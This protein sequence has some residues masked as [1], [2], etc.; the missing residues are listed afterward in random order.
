MDSE[1]QAHLFEPF[2][3]TKE[4]GKGTGLGLATVSGIVQQSGGFIW[5][6]SELGRGTTFKIYLP[7]VEAP[8]AVAVP[9]RASPE[10]LRGTE[11]VL[12]VEDLSAVRAV[13]REVLERYGYS[14]LTA[15]DG[16]AALEVAAAYA[17]QIDLLLTDVV[18]PK[19]S[20]RDVADRL[21]AMR[22]G[23]KVLYMSGYTDDAIV[24]HGVLQAGIAYLQKPFAPDALV[25]KVSEALKGAVSH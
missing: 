14:V 9:E 21:A 18:I 11:T 15:A 3:T 8:V 2:F 16:E 10:T 4:P 20:G 12:L 7:A 22:P 5:V 13:T 1:T 17:G 24:R 6:Y 23:L 19:L 25:R